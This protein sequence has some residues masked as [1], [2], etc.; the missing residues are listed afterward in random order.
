MARVHDWKP[1]VRLNETTRAYFERLARIEE[2]EEMRRAMT[3]ISAPDAS[4]EEVERAAATLSRDPL[5]NA[6]LRTG[7]SL[8]LMDGGFRSNVIPAEGTATFN[9]RVLPG[10]DIREVVAAMNRV[11]GMPAAPPW[12]GVW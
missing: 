12:V 8:T 10:E 1:P 6:V 11:G 5:H 7:A 4:A 2:D 3:A 9:V